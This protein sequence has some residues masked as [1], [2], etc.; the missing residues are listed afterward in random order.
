MEDR[1][2][3]IYEEQAM[4]GGI[5]IGGGKYRDC[6]LEYDTGKKTKNG[7]KVVRCAKYGPLNDAGKQ[8]YQAVANC[9]PWLMFL[10]DYRARHPREKVKVSDPALRAEYAEDIQKWYDAAYNCRYESGL[11]QVDYAKAKPQKS[12]VK[13]KNRPGEIAIKEGKAFKVGSPQAIHLHIH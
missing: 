1:Y 11:N 9:N 6:D 7:K 4:E 10:E 5:V 13:K 2:R 3:E 12:Y 8:H